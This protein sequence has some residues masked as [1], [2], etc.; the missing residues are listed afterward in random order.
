MIRTVPRLTVFAS[1][2]A[3]VSA[4]AAAPVEPQPALFPPADLMRIGVYYYPEAWPAAEWP[5]DIANMK[6]MGL[7]FVHMGEFAWAFMEPQE[8]KFD[9]AWLDRCVQLCADQGLKVV[10]CTPS[11]APPVW[12]TQAHPEVL[13]VDASGRRMQHGSREQACWNVA[14]YRTYVARIDEE[15]GRRYGHDPRVWGW[16][17]DNELSHYGKEPCY[18][19]ACQAAFRTWLRK[20]YGTIDALNRDWGNA[21]WSLKYRILTRSASPTSRSSSRSRT[22]MPCSMPGA[23]SP[24]RRPTTCA[25]KPACSARRSTHSNGSPRTS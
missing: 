23:G 12:L 24:M 15:L 16:Q 25:S 4:L 13:M 1:L 7:E 5:R 22:R 21:F 3:A 20:K 10:L 2:L 11:A 19:D 6:T 9:F 8:G 17:I 18:C 14:A